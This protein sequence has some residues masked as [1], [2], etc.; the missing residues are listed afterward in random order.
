[1]Q[2]ASRIRRVGALSLAMLATLGAF[3]Q[4]APQLPSP[5]SAV[6][7]APVAV[8]G[9]LP[10]PALWKVSKDGHVMWVLGITSPLPKGM[11]WE[12]SK[13]E[14]L[15]ASSQ[16]V[17]K[18][19]GMEIGAEVGL[20]GRLTLI[21]AMVGLKK[22]PDGQT[23]QQ[24]L[25]PELYDRWLIQ[26]HKYLQ[27][28]RSVDRLRPTF[29]GKALYGAALSQS[30]LTGNRTVENVVYAAAGRGKVS[31]IDT[32]YILM[33]DDPR[34]AAKQFKQASID[35]QS[36]L[37]GILDE[38]DQDFSQATERANAW[39]IGD[40][41]ALSK[42]LSV[43]QQD[44]CFSAIGNA[45]F[46]KTIGMTDISNRIQQAWIKAAEAALAHAPQ[47]V[48]LLPMNLLV[49]GDGYLKV[50]E[51]GGYTVEPPVSLAETNADY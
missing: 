32:H 40:L 29:A 24:A 31:V 48:A 39:A 50:L 28:S 41:Q 7:L 22:L 6:T 16:Q 20:W 15:I 14:H 23:L 3:A 18:P 8:S 17:L 37:R 5:D 21:P 38:I 46:A 19:P 11:Q 49:A 25:P 4:T 34:H 42:V 30:G 12:S 27:D 47:S 2:T 26:K 36:C 43:K 1:M 33:L 13:V 9:V 44:E 10:G 35:D 51:K 45:S